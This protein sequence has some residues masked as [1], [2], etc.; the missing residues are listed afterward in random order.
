MENNQIKKMNETFNTKQFNRTAMI[1][2]FKIGEDKERILPHKEV[3][4][5]H[6]SEWMSIR[7]SDK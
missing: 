1:L 7:G 5:F 6:F 4:Y 3:I 2:T